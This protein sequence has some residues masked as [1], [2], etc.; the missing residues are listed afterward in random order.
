M[1]ADRQGYMREGDQGEEKG[2]KDVASPSI[3]GRGMYY[4]DI[5]QSD[6]PG[7]KNVTHKN[8]CNR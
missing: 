2:C 4:A 3:E 6:L 1:A 7:E 5:E 8:H